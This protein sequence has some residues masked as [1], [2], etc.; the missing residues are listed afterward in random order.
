MKVN[1]KLMLGLFGIL[2]TIGIAGSIL[3]ARLTSIKLSINQYD[4]EKYQEDSQGDINDEMS[5]SLTI[6]ALALPRYPEATSSPTEVKKL[7][8]SIIAFQQAQKKYL[9]TLNKYLIIDSSDLFDSS[10]F[11]TDLR[12]QI[13]SISILATETNALLSDIV[14]DLENQALVKLRS[15]ETVLIQKLNAFNEEVLRTQEIVEENQKEE[16]TSIQKTLDVF[17]KEVNSFQGWFVKVLGISVGIS[18]L[19]SYQLFQI[20]SKPIARLQSATQSVS[21]GSLDTIVTVESDDEIGHLSM[22]FNTM[23]QK[24][25]S[26]YEE[27]QDKITQ[28]EDSETKLTQAKEIAEEANRAKSVFLANMSHELRTPLNAIIG[29]SE[30]L[31][32]EAEDMG[33]E[34][35]I[36][37]LSKIKK[38]GKHLLGLINDILDISKIEAGRMELYIE[39]IDIQAMI[40]DIV[41]TVSP[42]IERNNNHVQV[43]CSSDIGKMKADLTKLRQNLFNLMS[44]AS[45]F[46]QNG[47]I[48]VTVLRKEE[49][50]YFQIRDTGIGMSSEQ[51]QKIFKPFTQ[52][53]GS[54]TRKYGGTGLG[55]SITQHFCRMMGG[56]ITA[57]SLIGRGSTFIMRLPTEVVASDANQDPAEL[58]EETLQRIGSGKRI[59][60]IDDDLSSQNY[61]ASTLNSWGF[62]VHSALNGTEGFVLAKRLKPDV[63]TLDV[64]MPGIDGWSVLTDLKAN[65]DLAHI[66]VIMTTFIN[67]QN[68]GYALGAADYIV[69][70]IDRQQLLKTLQRLNIKAGGSILI[71]E[72]D[73][74][75]RDVLGRQLLKEGYRVE[76]ATNGIQ[77]LE[78]LKVIQPKLILLD[79]M[80]PQM[81]GFQV[82]DRLKE[83]PEW[84]SIPIVVLTAKDLDAYDRQRLQGFVESI[85]RKGNYDRQQFMTEVHR[86]LTNIVST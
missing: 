7:R 9:G 34:S 17:H 20:I 77:A 44:N 81:D 25:K 26:T 13:K 82:I 66:P 3:Y 28:L 24:L 67:D 49:W 4:L 27:L 42:L 22:T 2:A 15:D 45:K 39:E 36:N 74:M 16:F 63:I 10:D 31:E 51:L 84:R 60:I 8:S 65:P 55:L 86:L 85:Y 73:P 18:A 69:K 37:D 62:E 48:T 71:V 23:M 12:N 61:I 68:L 35:F 29:Y 1:Q 46:T 78:L 11:A 70:P 59:L 6:L 80:M 38:A 83:T 47:L 19:I 56:D 40:M 33:E 54:T 21:E 72:D 30:M 58:K 53:D 79:L 5:N 57:K 76:E 32:E 52:A 75:N 43:N 41:N 14:T 50:I 64:M